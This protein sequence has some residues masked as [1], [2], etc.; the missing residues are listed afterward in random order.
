[1]C[2]RDRP[3]APADDTLAMMGATASK[4][5]ESAMTAP[6]KQ[7]GAPLREE[8]VPAHLMVP[9]ATT[10]ALEPE[11]SAGPTT[12]PTEPTGE[13]IDAALRQMSAAPRSPCLLYT[14]RCV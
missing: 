4:I 12:E 14:S 13:Q 8:L 6:G 5:S 11:P 7:F 2:I 9:E 10:V 1:M 3:E